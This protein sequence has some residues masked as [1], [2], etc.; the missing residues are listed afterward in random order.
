MVHFWCLGPVWNL[1][2]NLTFS[3]ELCVV[4][5]ISVWF[6][7]LFLNFG[8]QFFI[9]A[10]ELVYFSEDIGVGSWNWLEFYFW[11]LQNKAMEWILMLFWRRFVGSLEYAGYGFW[12]ILPIYI[13]IYICGAGL[14][15]K[16]ILTCELK[17]LKLVSIVLGFKVKHVKDATVL[18]FYLFFI[19]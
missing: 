5:W 1:S 17:D 6:I 11:C 19:I 3:Y 9:Q 8:L 12:C 16:W 15:V 10:R 18:H 2:R 4:Y 7:I 14:E 13:Y